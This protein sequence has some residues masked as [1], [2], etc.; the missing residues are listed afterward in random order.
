MTRALVQQTTVA[1]QVIIKDDTGALT[2]SIFLATKLFLLLWH[3]GRWVS[4]LSYEAFML[5][6]DAKAA[7]SFTRKVFAI[8]LVSL[9]YG[10][11]VKQ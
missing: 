9:A 5:V 1:I 2:F 8:G 4:W 10:L 11:G 7:V 6:Q 3:I